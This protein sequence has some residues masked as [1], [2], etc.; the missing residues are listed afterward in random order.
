MSN[1]IS[2]CN[3]EKDHNRIE[4]VDVFKGIMILLVVIGFAT[5]KFN[6]W[7]YQFYMAAFFFISGFLFNV[8]KKNTVSIV[9][10]SILTLLLPFAFFILCGDSFN[11]IINRVGVYK[12]LFGDEYI[13]FWATIKEA[14]L[15]NRLYIQYLGTLWFIV[16][17]FAIEITIALLVSI[18]NKK[19]DVKMITLS[20]LLFVLGFLS[21]DDDIHL[22]NLLFNINIL[23]ISQ[24]YFVL[25]IIVKKW[26]VHTK[27]L[28]FSFLGKAFLFFVCAVIALLAKLHEI[29]IGIASEN[30]LHQFAEPIVIISSIIII[31]Y[32]AAFI[33]KVSKKLKNVLRFI[34]KDSYGIMIFFF[35]FFKLFMVALY[36]FGSAKKK[37]IRGLVLPAEFSGKYW[38]LLTIFS[39]TGAVVIWE[40]LKRI[41]YIR[42]LVGQDTEKNVAISG[43]VSELPTI[44]KMNSQIAE[45]RTDLFRNMDMFLRKHN[46]LFFCL[47]AIII[48]FSIPQM[49]TGII[50]NDELQA[51]CLAMQGFRKFYTTEFDGWKAQGR[52]LAAPINSFTKYLSFIWPDKGTLFRLGSVIILVFVVVAYTMMINSIF[53]DIRFAVFCGVSA[54]SCMPIVFEHMCPGAFVGFIG[55]SAGLLFCSVYFYAKYI[56]VNKGKYAFVSMLLFFVSMMSYEAFITFTPLYLMIVFGLIKYRKLDAK[57]NFFAIPVITS[58]LYLVCYVVSGKIAQSG[59]DG[60]QLGFDNI[61]GPLTIIS[62]LFVVCIPGFFVAFS[63]YQSYKAVLYNLEGLDYLRI[64]LFAILFAYVCYKLLSKEYSKESSENKSSGKGFKLYAILC[65][66]S[67]MILPSTPN[68]VSKMYQDNVSLDHG[69]LCL[70]ITFL[71]YF[72]ASFV[73]SYLIMI[74][75]RTAHRK[76]Y[77]VVIALMTLLVLNIQQMNDIFSKEQNRNFERLQE[78]EAFLQTDVI[79]GLDGKFYYSED[80]YKQENLLA[81]HDNYWSTYCLDVLDFDLKIGKERNEHQS[82]IIGYNDEVFYVVDE[83]RIIVFS[84][85]R[86]DTERVMTLE[87]EPLAVWVGETTM[88][89]GFNVYSVDRNDG[90]IYKADN[91]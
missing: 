65:G 49:R 59:Y 18:N 17:L 81:I 2:L 47:L 45:K 62:T 90:S 75:C 73:M 34:G 70:P 88:D 12:A 77:V 21:V 58:I 27:L 89:N 44:K 16:T 8:E 3:I 76:Y 41:R 43:R 82:G 79:K 14:F 1:P 60:N 69:F 68:S 26:Q 55:F 10:K 46:V 32:T 66:I 50:I 74:L 72:A 54:L 63:R 23:L 25:G 71:E 29:T 91:Y 87:G 9:M 19:V 56:S 22:E 51:R 64:A 85:D 42:F 84:R 67:Y 61:M 38:L 35:G 30:S 6:G 57:I 40:V 24:F 5:G 7:I 78:I 15:H 52:L 86:M 83:D 31:F 80:L 39:V 53:R 48:L 37:Q 28:E 11:Y 33:C 36:L 4:W 20:F 13:G